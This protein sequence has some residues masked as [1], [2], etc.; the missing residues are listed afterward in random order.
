MRRCTG[1]LICP[2]Q[3]LERLRHFV[4]R[5]A[6]DIEGL[7]EKT[8]AEF[9]ALGWLHTP[10]DIFR[11]AA[12]AAELLRPRGLEA[13]LRA[14]PA[15]RDRGAPDR[16]AATAS[17]TRSASAGSARPTPSC[18]PAITAASPTG[19]S[20]CSP[21]RRSAARTAPRSPASSASARR[22]PKSSP[23][24][25]PNRATSP[26]WTTSPRELTIEDAA[27]PAAP[28]SPLAGK[29]IVFTGS[30]ETMTRPEAKSRAEALG[31]RVT[32]SV[33]KKTDLV[34]LGADAGSKAKRAAELG[35]R[36]VT[37]A[38]WRELAGLG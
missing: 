36:T 11:L 6:F 23:S 7:G 14:E 31:A 38:E 12:H 21:P 26:S 17:S 2:A 10:A 28:D 5:A 33:S 19:A 3:A 13:A 32:D 29:I 1:G 24:S 22:S 4:S 18:W 20:R 25:S 9:V 37:E 8:I 27:A 30:L 16:P 15:A 35:V 34:V